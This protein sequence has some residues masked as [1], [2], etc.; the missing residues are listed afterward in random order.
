MVNFSKMHGAGNDFVITTV[1]EV[2]G[3]DYSVL[4]KNVCDRHFGIG[5]DGLMIVDE[6][7]TSDVRMHYYNSDGSL[8]EMCGNGIRCFSKFVY[9]KE[10][11][12]RDVFTVETLAGEKVI[13]LTI[14]K[15]GKVDSILVDMGVPSL[16]SQDV[17]VIT[18]RESF[19]NEDL[20]IDGTSLKVSSILMGVPHT[21]VFTEELSE[22]IVYKF[23][24]VIEKYN[25][26]PRKTNVNF[27]QV[28]N[29]EFMKVDTWERGAG[30]TLACGTGVCSSVFVANLLNYVGKKVLV[31]VPGGKLNITIDDDNRVFMEGTAE[32]ICDGKYYFDRDE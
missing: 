6:S 19:I 30:K 3:I 32:F 9:E 7:E 31:N 14:A 20:V 29:E 12:N 5:A 18:E 8:G 21:I 10:I 22:E 16:K 17:P 26:Y 24:P 11:V 13:N 23:G 25:I 15:D 28:I 4:A 2:E 27:V 1:E